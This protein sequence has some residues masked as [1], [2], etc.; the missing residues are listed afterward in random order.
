M[1]DLTLRAS[2]TGGVSA[3][4]PLQAQCALRT[5][6]L[7][8][9]H[10]PACRWL[11]PEDA[12][13]RLS[14]PIFA[15]AFAGAAINR[16]TALV[17]PAVSGVAL[18]LPPGEQP[19]EKALRASIDS[20]VSPQRQRD[21]YTVF[22]EMARLHPS[23]AHWYLPLIGVEPARQ[24]QGLGSA[25]LQPILTACDAAGLPAYLEA[26]SPRSVPL[27]SR[28]GFKA[29]AEIRIGGCPPIVP[30]LRP[31]QQGARTRSPAQLSLLWGGIWQGFSRPLH[32]GRSLT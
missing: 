9:E 14:F 21:V 6:T 20:T 29:T 13:Y 18:W 8:F 2:K 7:A 25:L 4:S 1:L 27:Y 24:R 3:L 17:T 30:M 11:F 28:H 23:E 32:P 16:G 22:A 12:Q 15:L 10:D 19:A 26:T 31:P 5:L